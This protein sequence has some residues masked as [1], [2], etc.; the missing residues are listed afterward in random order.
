MFTHHV[1]FFNLYFFINQEGLKTG[2]LF[3]NLNS[4]YSLWWTVKITILVCSSSLYFPFQEWNQPP[5]PRIGQ[6]S[7][8][9]INQVQKGQVPPISLNVNNYEKTGNLSVLWGVKQGNSVVIFSLSR[10]TNLSIADKNDITLQREIGSLHSVIHLTFTKQ[11]LCAKCC[12][13]HWRQKN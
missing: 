10:T 7:F 8:G 3:G 9:S 13:G 1:S 2:D 5:W 6:S 12:T 4:S 11:L